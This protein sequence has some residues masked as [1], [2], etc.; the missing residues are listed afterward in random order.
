MTKGLVTV[1][2]PTYNRADL[3]IETLESIRL[4]SYPSMEIIIIDDGSL[5]NTR[6]V[7][8]AWKKQH[9]FERCTIIC[10][11]NNAGKSFAVNKGFESANGEF[12]MILDSDDILFPD[13]IQHEV[14]F[15]RNYPHDGAVFGNA[16]ELQ[17]GIKTN[18]RYGVPFHYYKE[19][20]DLSKIHG[21]LFLDGNV[22]VSSTV[23]MRSTIIQQ[24]GGFKN[25]QRII[26]DWDYWI[27]LSRCSLIGYT[28]NNIVYYRVNTSGA[29]SLNKY[30]LYRETV[31]LIRNSR[32]NYLHYIIIRTFIRQ[33]RGNLMLAYRGGNV[34][35]MIKIILKCI[36][37]IPRIFLP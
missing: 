19:F 37:S 11:E 26:H 22:I 10:H 13:A 9:I 31:D 6:E 18:I 16:F 32:A 14:T 2:V 30:L 21:D 27:R 8:S 5:D 15:L 17:G 1:I 23:L 24:V 36:L 28:N 4:Q 20:Q 25:E 12:V 34:V 33:T 7:I 3:I 29:L 35:V